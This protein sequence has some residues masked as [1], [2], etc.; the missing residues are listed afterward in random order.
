MCIL[1]AH[2]PLHDAQMAFVM[3]L[4]IDELASRLEVPKITLERWIRTGRIPVELR[5]DDCVFDPRELQEW[6]RMHDVE[7]SYLAK[8]AVD[9]PPPADDTLQACIG[10]GGVRRLLVGDDADSVLRAVVRLPL[11]SYVR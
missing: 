3:D 11:P 7:L 5:N 1:G 10:R 9:P 8:L 2:D 4:T 6:A